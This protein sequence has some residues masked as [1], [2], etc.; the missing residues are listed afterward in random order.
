VPATTASTPLH[1]K[2]EAS[3]F[4]RNL[5]GFRALALLLLD[6]DGTL[7]P[8]REKRDEAIPYPGVREVLSSLRALDRTRIVF[9]S[10]RSIGDL[11]P[12]L[13][14]DF[15]PEIWGSHGWEHQTSEGEYRIGAIPAAA[16]S[17]LEEAA[18][19][20]KARSFFSYCEEKPVAIA[21][22]WRGLPADEVESLQSA[23][24]SSWREIAD[25]GGLDVHPFDGGVELR[26]PG[27]DKGLAVRSLRKQ[28]AE[29]TPAAFLGDDL[30]DED[31][32]EAIASFGLGVLVRS[33]LRPTRA[34]L[35]I[36]PPVELLS[37]L[38]RWLECDRKRA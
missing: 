18:A 9:V 4:F 17:A 27:R 22:H 30:T 6:Y 25:R 12:L 19:L 11:S 37:F 15:I 2:P 34:R 7:A 16:R 32:F 26:V 33:E 5:S 36:R 31:A 23:A 8:F 21:L 24:Q 10:G 3:G 1:S 38:E 13:G 35:W 28:T 20:A 29:G 14:L